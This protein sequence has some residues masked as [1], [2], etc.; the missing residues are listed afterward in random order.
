MSPK[1]SKDKNKNKNKGGKR[2]AKRVIK[3]RH[4]LYSAAVQSVEADVDF[5]EETFEAKRGRKPV[6]LKEDFCGTAVLSCEWIG[7]NDERRAIGVDLDAATLQWSREN[8]VPK[9]GE[10]ESRLTLLEKNVNDITEPKV[11]AVAAFNFSYGVFKTR[12]E[13]L[14]YFKTARASLADDGILFIDSFG[15]QE[16]VGELSEKRRIE[17]EKAWNGVEVPAFTYIWDQVRFNP[18]DHHIL[19]KIHF[20]LADGTKLNEAFVYDWRLWTLPELQELMI[21]AGFKST[22][23]YIEGWDE[24]EDDTDG[25]FERQTYFENQEGWVAYVI[26]LA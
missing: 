11:D 18:V 4:L 9:L 7:R 16:S 26:A 20:K 22:E 10:A 6:T 8:Y 15:G 17:P 19:C 14:R 1:K 3:D 25:I 13:L 21:E 5:V 24:E 23:V 12:A 2:K